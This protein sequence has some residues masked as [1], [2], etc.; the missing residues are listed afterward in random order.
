MCP[1]K[2]LLEKFAEN[3]LTEEMKADIFEHLEACAACREK[4][5][6]LL[7]EDLAVLSA[8][9]QVKPQGLNTEAATTPPCLS[10]PLLLAYASASL[11]ED[12]LKQVETHL[13][14]C[15][16]CLFEL[17]KL[18][19]LML[20]PAELDMDMS[21]LR[22]GAAAVQAQNILEIVLK[23]KEDFLELIRHTGELI[24]PAPQFG[25]VRGRGTE[26]EDKAIVIRKDFV[27]KDLSVELKISKAE[28]KDEFS[29]GISVMRL[30][31][32]EFIPG[33]NLEVTG[34]A[35][36]ESAITDAGGLAVF[37]GIRTGKYDI[38]IDGENSV[39]IVLDRQQRP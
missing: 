36:R 25:V 30:G 19:R 10:R 17:M 4:A 22:A 7:E 1:D 21:V 11:R 9:T 14:K 24:S 13:E 20:A 39:L 26:E 33:M 35:R 23:L 16:N 29:V 3:E 5:R 37:S 15:D 32:E 6:C 2:E 27:E 28:I 8:L 12:R 38:N 34:E 31:S 18:Q